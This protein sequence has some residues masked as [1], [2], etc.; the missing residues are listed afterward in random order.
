MKIVVRVTVGNDRMA[1]TDDPVFL[2]LEGPTGRE[3]RLAPARGRTFRRG[4]EEVFVL[5]SASDPETNVAHP[6]IN[7]PN[8]S[9]IYA[10]WI[11]RAVLYKGM[12]PI[13]NVR[14]L[15][16]MDDRVQI[17]RVTLELE[18]AGDAH[19]ICYERRGPFWLG[20]VC[21]LAVDLDPVDTNE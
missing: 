15:G 8:T 13:P 12:E 5:G 2:R 3:F 9:P 10:R 11:Q 1:A 20:L 21:G 4:S 18:R 16:E 6:E 17:E 14:G 7:D 19:P